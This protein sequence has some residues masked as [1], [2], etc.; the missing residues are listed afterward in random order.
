MTHYEPRET[1]LR[2]HMINWKAVA[3]GRHY[4]FLKKNWRGIMGI[5]QIIVIILYTLSYGVTISEVA[6]G[7]KSGSFMLTKT[8]VTALMIGLLWWGGF[9]S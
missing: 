4:G 2:H 7:K 8:F 3:I 5:P 9:F 6:D 1:V